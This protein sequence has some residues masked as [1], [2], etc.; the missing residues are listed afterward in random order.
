MVV[1]QAAVPAVPIVKNEESAAGLANTLYP[2]L[3]ALPYNRSPTAVAVTALILIVSEAT[4]KVIL[5]SLTCKV[6]PL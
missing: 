6:L 5:S 2:A 4:S 1:V 3:L